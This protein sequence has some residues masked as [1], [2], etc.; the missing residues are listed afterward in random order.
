LGNRPPQL[1]QFPLS[2]RN[3]PGFYREQYRGLY[4]LL[5]GFSTVRIYSA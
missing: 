1:R 2:S 5:S 3:A 4:G